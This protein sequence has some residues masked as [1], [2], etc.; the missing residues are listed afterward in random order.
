MKRAK[1]LSFF[2]AGSLLFQTAGIDAMATQANDPAIVSESVEDSNQ[3]PETDDSENTGVPSEAGDNTE[4]PST[5]DEGSKDPSENEENTD[6]PSTGDEEIEDPS[7]N[8]EDP[9]LPSNGDEEAENPS[10]N[11]EDSELPSTEDEETETP[12]EDEDADT[13][14]ESLPSEDS[15]SENTISENTI[16]ENTLPEEEEVNAFDIFP[17]LGDNYLFSSKQLA[18]KQDLASHMSDIVP[19]NALTIDDYS[20]AEGLYKLGEVVYLADTQAEAEQIAAAFGGT[21]ESYSYE[22]AVIRLPEKAT[23][24]LAIAAAADPEIKLPAVWPNY[25]N[26][27]YNDTSAASV[28]SITNDP[29]LA[30]QWQHDYI[31]TSYAWA[32]G[33]KGQN[34][35]IAV[36]D[37]GLQKDHPDF[38]GNAIDG[39]NFVGGAGGITYNSDNQTHGT[40]VAGIIAAQDNNSAGGAGIAPDAKVSGYCVFP[41]NG[42]A[43]TADVMAAINAAVAAKVD[44][45]NMSLGSSMYIGSYAEVIQKA[46]NNGVAVFAAAGNEDV[47]AN[48][49]PASY[50]GAISV[51]AVD[52]N[53]AKATFSNYGSTVKLSFPGVG[54]YS[55]LPTST[56]GY[57]SGTSQACPAAAGT[58]AVI[59]SARDDIKTKSGKAKVDALLSAMK[60]S[61]TKCTSSGMGSGTTWLPGVL[62]LATDTTAPDMP[63]ITIDDSQY[64]KDKKGNYIAESVNVTLSTQTAVGVQLYYTTDGK[65]PTYKNGIF[66][67]A[68][69][70]TSGNIALGGAK[71][72]TIKAVALNPITGKMSKVA[73]KSFNFA[74]LP[75]GVAIASANN[76]TRIAAGKSI[77]LTATVTPSY[78]ASTKVKWSV[79]AAATAAYI[80]VDNG[81]TVKTKATKTATTPAGTYTVTAT[82]L[83]SDGQ[84][85]STVKKDFTI[86]VL[87]TAD[88]KTVA[89]KQNGKAYRAPALNTPNTLDLKPYLQVTKQDNTTGTAAD[90]V[91]SSS[92]T[93]VATVSNGVVT[94]VASGRAT[95][96]AISNDG[97]NKSASCSI[98]VNQPVVSITIPSSMKVAAGKTIALTAEINKNAAKPTN[99]NLTWAV[100]GNDKVTVNTSG[101]VSA[102]KDATGTCTVTATAKDGS[103]VVSN[104]CT[105]TIV[106]GEITKIGLNKK[107]L[108]LFS[109]NAAINNAKNAPT[110]ETLDAIIDGKTGCDKTQIIWTSSAPNIAAVD[111]TGKVTA[112]TAG[113]ATITCASTD[114]SNKKASCTVNV[115]IPMSKLAIGPVD[116]WNQY[117]ATEDEYQGI[118]AAGKNIKMSA[119]YS[120]NYGVPTNKK[121]TWT[122]SN[123][124]ILT[125]DKNGKV[126]ANKNAIGSSATITATAADGSGVTSNTYTFYV[127]PCYDDVIIMY[128]RTVGGYVVYGGVYNKATGKWAIS[129]PFYYTVSC[130]GGKNPGC[131]RYEY[132]NQ[133]VSYDYLT[134]IPG[135]ATTKQKADS[136]GS[137]LL[138]S[139]DFTTLKLT[140]QLRDG[141]GRK[142]S[143][144]VKVFRLESGAYGYWDQNH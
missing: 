105:V 28:A 79:D 78:A 127:Q 37:T 144:N 82:A 58:A 123:T 102:K 74:P 1:L 36:I 11:E 22:V 84:P 27:L 10:E 59:L 13:S 81:G 57:M 55:T 96:K 65:N 132:K 122:S 66:T 95:I 18:D 72:V 12:S 30:K 5:G 142:A 110:T 64:T 14:D 99:K 109:P 139:K 75:T 23:V 34:V 93:K 108:T 113:K 73:S 69:R 87:Q 80:T 100:T 76:V 35:T 56:Y 111:N 136:N 126:T 101:K 4:L 20:D 134:P 31:G 29:D 63:K 68:T 86:T 71:K 21:L 124:N 129:T 24:S 97:G 137:V 49:F 60:S 26:Y 121:I 133:D 47:K 138:S 33:Y 7:E 119:R 131:G 94:A 112:K 52:Q 92:N 98:T 88:I 51:G 19:A 53:S 9:E 114:G 16:S 103:N 44:I 38:T 45:I 125:V 2:L 54:I 32:A 140:A 62:K 67:N 48:A 6:L 130:T 91:W 135:Q 115:T 118:I 25:Y 15:V 77:K 42:T 117:I 70:Y 116:S 90:V 106:S 61:T 46:Y 8:E 143:Y 40:H 128:D 43:E 85:I 39:R 41:T 17:G 89:F 141:S 104:T 107:T 3:A 83:G 50:P 120:S